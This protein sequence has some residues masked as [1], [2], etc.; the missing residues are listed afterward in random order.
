M[1]NLQAIF[2]MVLTIAAHQQQQSSTL[3][4]SD[5]YQSPSLVYSEIGCTLSGSKGFA[6][7]LRQW[8]A[9]IPASFSCWVLPGSLQLSLFCSLLT[10]LQLFE[11]SDGDYGYVLQWKLFIYLWN[12]YWECLAMATPMISGSC[13]GVSHLALVNLYTHTVPETRN[14]VSTLL[15]FSLLVQLNG[16]VYA[17]GLHLCFQS[18][19]ITIYRYTAKREIVSAQFT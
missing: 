16:A 15:C 13:R 6:T 1:N 8:T 9:L 3:T 2:E 10:K 19:W 14:C 17:C 5:N 12:G 4:T 18:D 7:V 11:P